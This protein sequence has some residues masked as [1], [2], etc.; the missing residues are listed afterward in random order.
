[1]ELKKLVIHELRKERESREVTLIL[2]DELVEIDESSITFM[3][4]LSAAYRNDK[5][6]YAIFDDSEGKYFPEKFL[7][8]RESS[9][10]VEDFISF[11]TRVLGN[12]ESIISTEF[13]ATGGYFVFTEYK[14]NG[15]DFIA[16]FLIRD[17]EGKI[18]RKTEHSYKIQTIE[19]VDTK[20]LAM[21]C[22]INENRINVE[23][24]N[25]ISLTQVKQQTISEYFK[26]WIS[27]QQLESSG[28]Y[29]D[30]LYDIINQLVPPIDES[31]GQRMDIQNVREMVYNYAIASPTQTI[32][33]AGLGELIYR[34]PNIISEY[35][36]NNEIPL[37]TEFKYS[38]TKL[39]KFVKFELNR[40]GINLKV[41]QGEVNKKIK[42][43]P[44]NQDIV[45]IESEIFAKAFKAK[46]NQQ[47]ARNSE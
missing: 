6:L 8:Y 13:L 1:M 7:E 17:V 19:Y 20:N 47:N 11:T 37:D 44:E 34:D 29:T 25:Y 22:R 33:I 10:L 32:N 31:T 46:L 15:I 27:I 41:S 40:D 18:L 12:L 9:R 21:A 24:G 39:R 35:A 14:E 28:N 3:G 30:A 26:I 16:I 42:L 2:S 43:S 36:I 38:K 5:I 45:I 23:E 4:A